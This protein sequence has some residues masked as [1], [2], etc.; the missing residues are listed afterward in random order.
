LL[1]PVA[2]AV[3]G[4]TERWADEIAAERIGD[5][6]LVASALARAA[7]VTRSWRVKETRLEFGALTVADRIA[8]LGAEPPRRSWWRVVGLCLIITATAIAAVRAYNSLD[9]VYDA[10]QRAAAAYR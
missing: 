1:R 7:D 5:R 3:Y 4:L 2:L 8:A 6:Q 9:V 10:A